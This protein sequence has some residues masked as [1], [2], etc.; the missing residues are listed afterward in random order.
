M[1]A[2]PF[3]YKNGYAVQLKD[4][5]YLDGYLFCSDW[6]ASIAVSTHGQSRMIRAHRIQYEDGAW[7]PVQ[8]GHVNSNFEVVKHP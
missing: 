4:G 6:I 2:K 1:D 5:T 3:G 8:E 7:S